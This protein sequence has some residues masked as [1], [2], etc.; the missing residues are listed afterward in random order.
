MK[1]SLLMMLFFL[2]NLTFAQK[3]LFTNI[4]DSTILRNQ[5]DL[6]IK[7]FQNQLTLIDPNFS[8]NG[9]KTMVRDSLFS[10]Y[11]LPKNNRIYLST[12]KATPKVIVDFCT[13]IMDDK[14]QGEKLAALY[15]FGYFLPHEIAHGIQFNAKVR[16]DNEYDNEYEA[17]VI[18]LL[19]W[20]KRGKSIEMLECYKMAKELVS[21]LKNPIPENEDRKKYFTEHY[22]EMSQNADQ[23]AYM[24]FSQIVNIFEDKN[25][26]DFDVYIKKYISK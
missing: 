8:F 19:Y 2:A 26:P 22:E 10:G 7:D 16:K 15:F 3:L 24:L 21:K 11:Y 17:N 23:Y 18:A 4:N 25:L 12:W 1:K 9:M 13:Q 5:N 14:Q 6:L 20:K